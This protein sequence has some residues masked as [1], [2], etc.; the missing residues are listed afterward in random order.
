[1][2]SPN[3]MRTKRHE[4]PDREGEK[5]WALDEAVY[6]LEEP[7]SNELEQPPSQETHMKHDVD[8]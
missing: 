4:S 7:T 6:E 2:A 5:A 3:I 1:M 8:G